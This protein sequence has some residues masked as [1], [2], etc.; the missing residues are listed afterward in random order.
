MRHY[1][2]L[3]FVLCTVNLTAQ[4]VRFSSF[5]S[6]VNAGDLDIP[7]NNIT[8]EAFVLITGDLT[9]DTL[10]VVSKHASPMD[11]NY[12]L[13][14][15]SFEI[16]TYKNGTTGATQFSK[17]SVSFPFVLNRWYHIA[18]SYNGAT[19]RFYINGCLLG[20]KS[21]SGN[22]F[23][24]NFKTAIGIM[25]KTS[26]EQFYGNIAEV[27]IWSVTRSEAQIK[28]NMANLTTP[29]VQ[30]GLQLYYKFNGNA[31]NLQGNATYNGQIKGNAAFDSKEPTLKLPSL[32]TLLVQQ[33]CGQNKGFITV[34]AP[35]DMVFS[36]NQNPFNAVFDF[37]NLDSGRYIVRTKAADWCFV[38]EDTFDF[39]NFKLK[40]T[41]L[42][43]TVCGQ[44]K[45][46]ITLKTTDDA[47]AQFSSDSLNFSPN[48]T[49]KNLKP[50]TYKV[51][52]KHN[53]GCI[54]TTTAIIKDSTTLSNNLDLQI[55]NEKCNQEN[56]SITASI[57]GKG[58]IEYSLDSINFSTKNQFFDLKKRAYTVYVR[59]SDGCKAKG[60]TTV[61][62]DEIS[63]LK[64]EKIE[65]QSASCGLSNGKILVQIN[66]NT[67]GVRFALDPT[68]FR[69]I[70]Y[71]YNLK[72]A[73]YQLFIRDS[74]KCVMTERALVGSKKADTLQFFV[75]ITPSVCSGKTGVLMIENI[76]NG[77]SP[78][79]FSLNDSTHFDSLSTFNGLAG[80]KY[81]VF[82]KDSAGCST[83][84]KEVVIP[85]VNCDIY[86]PT[87][88]SPNDDGNNDFLKIY[89]N[90]GL[91]KT[92]KS[93]Q[94]FNRW[95]NQIYVSP[96]QNT[97]FA[98]FTSWWDGRF[99][100]QSVASDV[101]IYVIEVEY[102]EGLGKYRDRILKGDMTIMR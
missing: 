16:T 89:A 98:A 33:P 8:V 70:N 97:D 76:K 59:N 68:Q 94:I 9:R 2:L 73:D 53:N 77:K 1:I 41:L 49:F 102:T 31:I 78:F 22:L 55:K 66:G 45:G 84:Q 7:S 38:R 32:N 72:E 63:Y 81:I 99:Q 74:N 79:L 3:T 91:I 27:R 50:N 44:A 88:F 6:W 5:G 93:Y 57:T 11:A 13:R 80:D 25:D 18:A 71:F 29:S 12:L 52:T 92:I 96:Q 4:S 86:V 69:N 51:F 10:N 36:L 26:T 15:N 20:E 67:E 34:N 100:G 75:K 14:P 37:P 95:G 62:N 101:Y 28:E 58:T 61:Q 43:N 56:G 83:A 23:Q 47:N 46:E 42:K 60:T 65:T 40:E 85:R 54:L 24:N 64:I 82:G 35:S 19:M 30:N 87:I 48:S 17:L 39:I 90:E 21:A